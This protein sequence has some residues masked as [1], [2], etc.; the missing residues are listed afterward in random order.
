MKWLSRALGLLVL[1]YWF[2][3]PAWLFCDLRFVVDTQVVVALSAWGS[4]TNMDCCGDNYIPFISFLKKGGEEE[5]AEIIFWSVIP[6]GQMLFDVCISEHTYRPPWVGLVNY[7][8][9]VLETNCRDFMSNP[10]FIDSQWLKSLAQDH[11][12]PS[13][14]YLFL[15]HFFFKD[16]PLLGVL[17]K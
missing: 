10:C 3:S 15:K 7:G 13:P 14:T 4:A 8:I 1:N 16:A 17:H 2:L 5:G 11:S 9:S 6:C 12:L